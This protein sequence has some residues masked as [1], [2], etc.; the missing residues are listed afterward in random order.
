MPIPSTILYLTES[1]VQQTLSI[2]EAVDLAEKG[3][4]ADAAG[5]CVGNKFYMPVNQDGFIKPFS[6]YIEG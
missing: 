6:G 2:S 5:N 3:I 4:K 1:E